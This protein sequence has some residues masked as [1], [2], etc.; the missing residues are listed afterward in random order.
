MNYLKKYQFLTLVSV[1]VYVLSAG[2][3]VPSDV[4]GQNEQF[5][6][7]GIHEKNSGSNNNG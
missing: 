4:G 1:L 2:S 6:F 3:G 5:I 7:S